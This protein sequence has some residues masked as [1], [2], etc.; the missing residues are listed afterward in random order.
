MRTGRPRPQWHRPTLDLGKPLY[1]PAGRLRSQE[2]MSWRSRVDLEMWHR[3]L[4]IVPAFV[5]F[6]AAEALIGA[7][8]AVG[9]MLDAQLS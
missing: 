9:R 2:P 4:E 3:G 8:I 6:L 5:K 1:L 7:E